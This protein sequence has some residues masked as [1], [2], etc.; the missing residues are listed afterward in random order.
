MQI[1][2][3]LENV[4]EVLDKFQEENICQE[5]EELLNLIGEMLGATWNLEDYCREKGVETK[6]VSKF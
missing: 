6:I 2:D 1:V 3:F 5:D 4:A